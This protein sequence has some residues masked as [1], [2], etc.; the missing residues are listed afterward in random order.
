[1]E[2]HF[3][4]L[5]SHVLPLTTIRRERALPWQGEVLVTTGQK[6]EP[7]DVVAR[8]GQPQQ[9]LVL[10]ITH[11]LKIPPAQADSCFIKHPGENV[12][13]GETLA[14]R[15]ELLGSRRITSPVEGTV[16]AI[17]SGRMVIRPRPDLFELR[18]LLSGVIASTTP[19][20][21]VTIETPGVL[22]QG[23]WGPGKESYGVLKMGVEEPDAVL[24]GEQIEMAHHGAILVCGATLDMRLLEKAQELQVRGLIVGGVPA[25]LRG[26]IAKLLL[27]VIATE[28]M[29]RISISPQVFN[30]LKANEGREA[31]MLAIAPNR[32]QAKRPEIIIPLPTSSSPGQPPA[33]GVA[34]SPGLKVRIRRAPYWGKVGTVK[35]VYDVPRLV[36]SGIKYAGAD[37]VLDDGT[38]VF[39]PHINLDLLGN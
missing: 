9:H 8:A 36:D 2:R 29:G 23:A 20:Y 24:M 25:E 31:M 26:A 17:K 1:M 19:S 38:R 16:V 32:W 7:S 33:Q 4:P 18:A 11:K 27:P 28:G 37:V 6:V 22:I 34:I 21:G 10:D 14:V 5:Q 3:Y 15:K 30:L 39:V 35:A 12:Q 13:Q